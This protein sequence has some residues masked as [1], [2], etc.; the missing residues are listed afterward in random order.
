[1]CYHTSLNI[2]Q[3]ALEARYGAKVEAG[4]TWEPMIHANAYSAPA[5]PIISAQ[6]PEII[7]FSQW[8][9]IPHWVKTGPDA[10]KLRAMTINARSETAFEKPSFRSAAQSGKRCL[11]P[12][13]GFFEWH[14][15]KKKKYPFY[16]Q[17][18]EAEMVSIAGLW[19]EWA[20]PDT[21]EVFMTY[22]ML[23]RSAN[24]LMARIHNGKERMPCLLTREQEADYLRESL[25]QE[26]VLELLS[27]PYPSEGLKAYS[28][29]RLITSRKEPTNVPEV[30]QPH[31]YPELSDLESLIADLG[32]HEAES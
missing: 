8:G 7:T 24:K 17:P 15:E 29:S 4:K 26:E 3:P 32:A 12:V 18:A 23:T 20:D 21:G 14:T 30:L 10:R 25:K 1:M 11:I 19:D 6:Q 2:K 31:H 13:S 9:L 27:A 5:L 16:I 22:T 28:I